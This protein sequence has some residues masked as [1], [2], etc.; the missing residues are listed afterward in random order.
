MVV[1]VEIGVGLFPRRAI[2]SAALA[3]IDSERV[4]VVVPIGAGIATV[5]DVGIQ[6]VLVVV[7]APVL[8]IGGC[9]GRGC[10]SYP[11]GRGCICRGR[12]AAVVV[13]MPTLFSVVRRVAV[14]PSSDEPFPSSRY[15]S[16]LASASSSSVEERLSGAVVGTP[17]AVVPYG[18]TSY[19]S[20]QPSSE[21][22]APAVRRRRT[23]CY[24]MMLIL[25]TVV[26][27]ILCIVVL[28]LCTVLA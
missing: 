22:V 28:V 18:S 6:I 23:Y 12:S 10:A 27:I 16:F 19:S 17:V 26:L 2:G 24:D 11:T 8:L 4:D 1:E 13:K 5:V 9:I 15:Q 21:K 14:V 25:Y 20:P 7:V 3:L